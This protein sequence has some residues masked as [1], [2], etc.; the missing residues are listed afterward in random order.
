MNLAPHPSLLR[1]HES[2][3][4]SGSGVG[5][6]DAGFEFHTIAWQADGFGFDATSGEFFTA[7]PTALLVMR[8]LKDGL[9]QPQ[10]LQR[11]L[12][13]YDVTART[14]ERDLACFMAEL[15]TLGMT[16]EV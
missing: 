5:G 4:S 13:T 6:L 3:H 15:E 1:Q 12:Q 2:P 7:S 16:P 9:T 8:A 11:L 10:V 14:A